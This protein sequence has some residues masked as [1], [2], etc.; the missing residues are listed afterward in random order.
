M[1]YDIK[2]KVFTIRLKKFRKKKNSELN[3]DVVFDKFEG[4]ESEKFNNFF[5]KYLEHFDGK[6]VTYKNWPKAITIPELDVSTKS[7]E[8]LFYGGFEGGPT[9]QTFKVKQ[10][11]NSGEEITIDKN[12]VTAQPFYFMFYIPNNSNVGILIVQA[13][14]EMSMHD[15]LMLNFQKYVKSLNEEFQLDYRERITK[16]AIESYKKGAVK[17]ISIR[18][19]GLSKDDGDNIFVKKYQDYGNIKLELKISFINRIASKLMLDDLKD[20]AL[21]TVPQLLEVESLES[22][23]MDKDIDVFAQFEYNGKQSMAKIE[24]GVKLSPTYIVDKVD[25]PLTADN[26]PHPVKIKEYLLAFMQKMKTEIGL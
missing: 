3:W 10:L 4:S 5:K 7:A 9:N 1:G 13:L 24:N 12:Q 14:G 15:I 19:S 11:D 17:S 6:F 8:R 20:Y 18:K 22:I 23:G 2:L 21:G 16:D 25:V 26:H